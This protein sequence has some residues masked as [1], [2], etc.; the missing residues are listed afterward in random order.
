M[1]NGHSFFV[2]IECPLGPLIHLLPKYRVICG[3]LFPAKKT[4]ETYKKHGQKVKYKIVLE[5]R[6]YPILLYKN[7][8]L[9]C[10]TYPAK[11]ATSPK[12]IKG[13]LWSVAPNK[14]T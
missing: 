13:S 6:V 11:R 1:K 3:Q 7:F 9:S 2:S 5:K 8:L 4:P 14:A 12:I 10:I